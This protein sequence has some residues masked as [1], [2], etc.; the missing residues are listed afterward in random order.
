M[1]LTKKQKEYQK[2]MFNKDNIFN[3]DACPENRGFKE[4]NSRIAGPCGQQNCW[5]ECHCRLKED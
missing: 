3:C 1:E 5:V 4:G 2:F